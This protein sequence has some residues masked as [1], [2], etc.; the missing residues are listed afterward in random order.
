MNIIIAAMAFVAIFAAGDASAM[1][2]DRL[3]Q[4]CRTVDA[5]E[6]GTHDQHYCYGYI[7]A[8]TENPV[9]QPQ[10]CR[11]AG[12]KLGIVVRVVVA[13]LRKHPEKLHLGGRGLTS[14]ALAEAYPCPTTP[15]GAG[16]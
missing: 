3:L 8:A 2:G 7:E 5:G 10:A 6:E 4:K 11:P 9:A 13:Y 1:D 15:K 16:W 12:I 14:D